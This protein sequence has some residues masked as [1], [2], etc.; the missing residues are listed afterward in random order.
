M[1]IRYNKKLVII[2]IMLILFSCTSCGVKQNTDKQEV[3]KK[4][5]W[6]GDYPYANSTDIF[7]VEK[8]NLFSYDINGENKRKLKA[9][10]GEGCLIRVTDDWLYFK[11]EIR[12]N[13][14]YEIEIEAVCRI[15]LKKGRDGRSVLAGKEQKVVEHLD[16][17]TEAIVVDKYL[18]YLRSASC[19]NYN[20]SLVGSYIIQQEDEIFLVDL[21]NNKTKKCIVPKKI[22]SLKVLE[23]QVFGSSSKGIVWGEKALF[24]YDIKQN[25]VI[26]INE[27]Q[28]S[29]VA[30]DPLKAEVYYCKENR[31]QIIE[32]YSIKTGER[33]AI[34]TKKEVLPVLANCLRVS[35]DDIKNLA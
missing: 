23:W 31:P 15:P 9:T 32:K 21:K 4:I 11:K 18:V 25:K 7:C 29:N 8:N 13:I 33:S 26:L 17:V 24:Y 34:I 35:M 3:K 5:T 19:V 1:A 6:E 14:L 20:N 27:K 2:M 16:G 10:M 12:K 22:T 28:T 30:F